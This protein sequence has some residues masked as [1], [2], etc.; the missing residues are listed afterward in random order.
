MAGNWCGSPRAEPLAVC[1]GERIQLSEDTCIE[2]SVLLDTDIVRPACPVQ[3]VSEHVVVSRAA[4]RARAR[5]VRLAHD[6][7]DLSKSSEPLSGASRVRRL[8]CPRAPVHKQG[9]ASEHSRLSLRGSQVPPAGRRE[10][11][12]P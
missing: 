10:L 2:L 8:P 1:E 9:L 5:G 7:D 6:V 3:Y 4:S 11:Q 12:R